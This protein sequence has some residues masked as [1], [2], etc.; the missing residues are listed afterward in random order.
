[1]KDLYETVDRIEYYPGIFAEDTRT[2]SALPSLIGRLVGV[3]AFSQALTNPLL[4]A[5]IYNELTFTRAGL[6]IIE[7]T[8]TLSDILHRNLPAGSPRFEVSMDRNGD[9]SI[10]RTAASGKGAVTGA[11]VDPSRWACERSAE[12]RLAPGDPVHAHA[13]V[14]RGPHR[15]PCEPG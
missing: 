2:N 13:A 6:E 4:A 7:T 3:D 8:Q 12:C 1:M 14:R 11:T 5:N 9:E 10:A 15:S